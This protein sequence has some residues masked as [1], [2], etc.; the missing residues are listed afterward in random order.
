MVETE[1]QIVGKI[2]VERQSI[3]EPKSYKWVG[4]IDSKSQ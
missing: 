1:V 3:S 4:E 2:K